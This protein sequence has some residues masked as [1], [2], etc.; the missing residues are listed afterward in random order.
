MI[1]ARNRAYGFSR[2]CVAGGIHAAG[3]HS[4]YG[5]IGAYGH[6][7]EISRG[8]HQFGGAA[9]GKAVGFHGH[10]AAALPVGGGFAEYDA[11]GGEGEIHHRACAGNCAGCAAAAVH[12]LET[13]VEVGEG[14]GITVGAEYCLL[15][16]DALRQA[17][18]FHRFH[19]Q[20]LG[21]QAHCGEHSQGAQN[22]FFH[23]IS[24][25][26]EVL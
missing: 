8:S 24:C 7:L 21:M 15:G 19:L 25:C 1:D 6:G 11:V 20:Q 18:A 9:V 23:G 12:N 10:M 17:D 14:D 4:Q 22:K 16:A 3:F 26:L 5:A 13:A 2:H